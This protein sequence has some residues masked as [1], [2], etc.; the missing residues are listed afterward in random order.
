MTV[1]KKNRKQLI[2]FIV[3]FSSGL[4]FSQT[5]SLNL[6]YNRKMFDPPEGIVTIDHDPKID[7]LLQA[8]IKFN[9]S[10]N[11]NYYRIQIYNGPL[12]G[13]ERTKEEFKKQ[14]YDW[15]CDISFESPNYKVRVGKFKTRLE[16]DKN[17]L[18]MRKKYS[19]A[20]LLIP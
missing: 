2:V 19:N 20:F 1:F 10:D 12:A 9:K 6:N 13:A 8:K 7:A 3:L 14:Y 15:S 18:E 11:E 16:A 5:D 17:L 4:A